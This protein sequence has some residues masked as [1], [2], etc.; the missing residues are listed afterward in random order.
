MITLWICQSSISETLYN[1][2]RMRYYQNN[3]GLEFFDTVFYSYLALLCWVNI[4]IAFRIIQLTD[5]SAQLAVN[6]PGMI[7]SF[8]IAKILSEFDEIAAGTYVNLFVYSTDDG[9]DLLAE[10][11]Y[12]VT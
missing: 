8:L 7:L 3:S 11:G 12:E 9:N 4:I 10:Q 6:A 1:F 5:V 2:K